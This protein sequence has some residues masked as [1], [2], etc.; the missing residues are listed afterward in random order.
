MSNILETLQEAKKREL[1]NP[2]NPAV[3]ETM[4]KIDCAYDAVGCE[5]N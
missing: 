2:S 4:K 3:V 5:L 1:W